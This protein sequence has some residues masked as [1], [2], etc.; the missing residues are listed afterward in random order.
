MRKTVP[1]RYLAVLCALSIFGCKNT[2]TSN[3]SGESAGTQNAPSAGAANA[4]DGSA[5]PASGSDGSGSVAS[6]LKA[7]FASKPIMV[8][9]GT[10]IVVVADQAVSSKTNNSGDQFDA[11]IAEPVVVGDR[12]VIPKG[13]RASGTVVDAKSAGR[14]KGNA[15]L[16]VALDSVTIKGKRYRVKTSEVTRATKGRGKRTA[17]GA[18]GGAAVGALIGAIAGGGKGAAIG[19]G[20]GAGAGTAGAAMTGERD[21]TINPESKLSFKLENAVAI[22]PK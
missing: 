6:N 16:T 9:P 8:K 12:V 22:E 20:A 5:S 11:S 3:D 21:V 7:V 13:A 19:A 10:E 17:E 18:G 14:F 2:A 15:E 1:I 4:P